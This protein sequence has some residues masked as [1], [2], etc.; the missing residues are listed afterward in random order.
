[1]DPLEQLEIQ[2]R[3]V[4]QEKLKSPRFSVKCLNK[5]LAESGDMVVKIAD[6]AWIGE[7]QPEAVFLD[8]EDR[9]WSLPVARERISNLSI[10]LFLNRPETYRALITRWSDGTWQIAENLQKRKIHLTCDIDDGHCEQ[11]SLTDLRVVSVRN[12]VKNLLMLQGF[13]VLREKSTEE[14]V[15]VLHVGLTRTGSGVNLLCGPVIT[16]GVTASEYIR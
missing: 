1:M 10:S 13:Q 14:T 7:D 5:Q 4:L 11:L 6:P 3:A 12:V 16:N 2:L 8:G 15:D 9:S